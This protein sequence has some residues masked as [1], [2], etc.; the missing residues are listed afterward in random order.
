M[1]GERKRG[2]NKSMYT[3]IQMNILT[4]ECVLIIYLRQNLSLFYTNPHT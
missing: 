2:E 1:K 3:V 4:F